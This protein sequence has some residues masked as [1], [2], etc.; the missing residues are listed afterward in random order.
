MK[1][2]LTVLAEGNVLS[3]RALTERLSN[4]L[5]LTDDERRQTIP[6]GMSLMANRVHWSVTY[7]FK[8]KAVERPQRGHV[9]ITQRGRDLL[10]AGGAIRNS[11]LEQFPEYLAFRDKF[12][13]KKVAPVPQASVAEDESPDDLIARAEADARSALSAELM[14]KVRGIEAVAFERLVLKLLGSMGYGG[15]GL[16]PLH[17]GQS[18]DGGIDGIIT[19]DKLGLDRIYLQAK[20][21]G[22][23]NTVQASEVRNFLGALMGKG[24]R[25]VFLTTSTFTSGARAAVNGVPAR[26]VLIDGEE[27]VELMIDHG[28]GVE[29]VRVATLHRINEDFFDAL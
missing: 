9:Q 20:R 1:P 3:M 16:E 6:S 5:G 7:L 15:S 8:A 27:L 2:V 13:K 11:S 10:A 14:E 12:R 26:V 29:P 25:G 18:G 22:A 17:T 19:E 28:V 4:D 23:S 21:Y 24:D